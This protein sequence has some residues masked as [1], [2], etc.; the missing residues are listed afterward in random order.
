[1]IDRLRYAARSL[2][3]LAHPSAAVVWAPSTYPRSPSTG[4]DVITIRAARGPSRAQSLLLDRDTPTSLLLTVPTIAADDRIGLRVADVRRT[5]DV[6]S[7][8]AATVA[9]DALL[10]EL[11]LADVGPAL[12]PGVTAAAVGTDQIRLTGAAGTMHE[13]QALGLTLAVESAAYAQLSTARASA[14]LE[15][16]AYSATRAPDAHGVLMNLEAALRGYDVDAIE[17][18]TGCIFAR[19]PAGEIV[20]LTALAGPTWESRAV[21]RIAVS[22]RTT[23]AVE[24]YQID[25]VGIDTIRTSP[26]GTAIDTEIL[27]P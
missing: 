9:R 4:G 7:G 2:A 1:M 10:A 22:L 5:V 6:A 11:V 17:D 25:A 18:E 8:T 14:L 26:S 16:T 27:A 3:L 19:H 13:P 23:R 20:D 12:L 21:V 15:V 24:I